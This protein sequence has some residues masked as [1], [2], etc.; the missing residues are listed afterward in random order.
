MAALSVSDAII[1]PFTAHVLPI[2]INR[3]EQP[4]APRHMLYLRR[5]FS[6]L[7]KLQF[8][9]RCVAFVNYNLNLQHNALEL[10]FQSGE[11]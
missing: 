8:V 6:E 5:V 7:I 2:L 11:K 4:T 3:P 1:K 10:F 9:H